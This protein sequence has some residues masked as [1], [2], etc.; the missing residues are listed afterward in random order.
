M[1]DIM[2]MGKNP[3]YLG[4]WDLD[5]LPNRE[6][7]LVIEQIRDEDVVAAGQKEVCT[8][9][10]WTDKAF[11][12]MIL[13][14]TNKKTIAK[15]Y[16]TKDTEKLK[17]KAVIIGIERVRAFGDVYDALR[18]RPRIPAQ[19]KQGSLPKCEKCGK[20]ITAAGNMTPEQVVDYRKNRY[21]KALCNECAKAAAE[22]ANK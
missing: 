3:N 8:V 15:L 4:S 10:H 11:K 20:D 21:G 16:K 7:T 6:V 1:A 9:A 13:N 5:E 17:G 2:K 14:V 19:P 22:G 18:I 12:P